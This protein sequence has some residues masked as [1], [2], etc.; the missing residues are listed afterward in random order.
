[1]QLFKVIIFILLLTCLHVQA[2]SKKVSKVSVEQTTDRMIIKHK[3]SDFFDVVSLPLF[4]QSIEQNDSKKIQMSILR[5]N[6][7]GATIVKVSISGEKPTLLE[8]K[9]LAKKLSKHDDIEYA[10]PDYIQKIMKPINKEIH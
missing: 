6:T 3:N 8:M 7:F 9:D 10:E 4:I 5:K 2:F 1:M